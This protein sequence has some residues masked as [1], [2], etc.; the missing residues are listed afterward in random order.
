MRR[1]DN[2]T[3][4]LGRGLGRRRARETDLCKERVELAQAFAD[5]GLV[6]GGDIVEGEGEEGFHFRRSGGG[7]FP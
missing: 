7:F 4:F 5:L 2:G 3:T 6:V 1:V